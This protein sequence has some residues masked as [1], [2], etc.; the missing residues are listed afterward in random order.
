MLDLERIKK[1]LIEKKGCQKVQANSKVIPIILDLLKDSGNQYE[2]LD[3]ID[4]QITSRTETLRYLQRKYDSLIHRKEALSKEIDEISTIINNVADVR[5][6][7][8]KE[9]IDSFY[10]SLEE[11]ET[12]EGRDLIKAAQVYV[13]TIQVKT[14]ADNTAFI[15]GLA[16]ILSGGK[17]ATGNEIKKVDPIVP[18]LRVELDPNKMNDDLNLYEIKAESPTGEPWRVDDDPWA[19][20]SSNDDEF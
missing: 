3:D 12:P 9:Y 6:K 4:R 7:Q 18:V 8:I 17:I 20:H 5:Y 19:D 1:D 13:N 10:K 15:L 2:T 16:A 14:G 11:C